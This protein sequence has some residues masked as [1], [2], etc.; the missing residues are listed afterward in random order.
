MRKVKERAFEEPGEAKK[1][2]SNTDV[3]K[4]Q[5]NIL[6]LRQEMKNYSSQKRAEIKEAYD[7]AENNG[8]EKKSLKDSIEI[9]EKRNKRSEDEKRMTNYYLEANGQ[10]AWYLTGESEAA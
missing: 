7:A 6:K 9:I 3:K 8:L 1:L 10:Q 5:D 4:Y 2:P